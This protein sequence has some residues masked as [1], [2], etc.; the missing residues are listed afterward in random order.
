M[1]KAI[2]VIGATGT[3][4]EPVARHLKEDGFQVRVMTRD[5]NKA[6]GIFD[7]TFDIVVGDV[8]DA[9]SLEE[10]LDG[11]F[12]V[13]ISTAPPENEQ[14]KVRNI[15]AAASKKRLRRITYVSW[16]N[17]SGENAW[18]PP[19]K[20]KLLAEEVIRGSGIPYT[21]FCPTTA[22]ENIPMFVQGNRAVVIGK[23]TRP[24]HWLAADDFGKVV[25]AS[26]G[27][28]ETAD[29]RLFIY[30]PEA[31]LT[32]EAVRRYC[33]MFCPEITKI[34]TMPYGLVNL[35]ATIMRS[36]EMK[37][38]SRLLVFCEKVDEG[39]DR[40]EAD[41]ILGA[42]KTTLDEWLRQMKEKLNASTVA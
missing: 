16:P 17:A 29:K 41:R 19:A 22:M 13:H 26:Y 7:E 40:T 35:M 11:C 28:E 21:I 3:M 36:K 10:P 38:G 4:G 24:Y 37:F 42:P 31:V 1:G 6:R 8:M 34:S 18:F 32:H 14:T 27:L 15:V 23:Q 25:S 12:G 9:S 5:S 30:G 33:S 20:Q 2:L 39:G